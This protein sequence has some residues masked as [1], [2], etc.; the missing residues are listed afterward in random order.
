MIPFLQILGTF[1]DCYVLICL[2]V[3]VRRRKDDS[4]SIDSAVPLVIST[5][6]LV[7]ISIQVVIGLGTNSAKLSAAFLSLGGIIAFIT[8]PRYWKWIFGVDVAYIYGLTWHTFLFIVA[9]VC[10]S[11]IVG[12]TFSSW[13]SK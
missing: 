5:L 3:L 13:H 1:L 2:D 11:N 6:Y 4:S 8:H 9:T 7:S 12:C 10:A